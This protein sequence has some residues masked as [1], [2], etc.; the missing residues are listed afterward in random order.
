MLMTP[1]GI[2]KFASLEQDTNA[3]SSIFVTIEVDGILTVSRLIQAPKA[4]WPI[5]VILPRKL[6]VT[7]LLQRLKTAVSMTVTPMGT[8]MLVNE[9]HIP[10]ALTPKLVKLEFAPKVTSSKFSQMSKA[11]PPM[12]VTESGIATSVKLSQCQ[13]APDSMF[14]NPDG[15]S[16][17]S[18]LTHSL[19]AELPMV[20]MFPKIVTLVKAEHAPNV[21]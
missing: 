19:N 7:R 17:L 6:A 16:M 11:E 15:R 13:K 9:S 21:P 10:N 2:E 14:S 8:V 20:V 3:P 18:R 12:L 4:L 5:L 1:F